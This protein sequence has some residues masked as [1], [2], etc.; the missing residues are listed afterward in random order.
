MDIQ[1]DARQ[2]KFYTIIDGREYSLEYNYLESGLWE[3]HC[4]FIPNDLIHLKERD[5]EDGL[6][7][8][9]LYYMARNNIQLLESGSCPLV[10]NYLE[11]KREME[12]LIKR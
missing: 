12:F 4:F 1:H 11:R 9:A 3:F 7:E 5:I 6:I 10:K 2:Q 8:Y